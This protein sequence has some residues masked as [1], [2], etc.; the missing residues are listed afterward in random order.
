V[1]N[2][3]SSYHA[4]LGRPALAKFMAVSHYVYVLLKMPGKIGVLTFPG[5]LK[6]SYDCD[7]EAIEYA[8][9]TLMAEPS[10]KVFVAT[11]Q[12]S[13]SEMV[14]LTKKS[15]QSTVKLNTNDIGM[16]FIQL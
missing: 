14:I 10:A 9:T 3:E 5:N 15:S 2:F 11:Q 6:K 12:L 16:K 7:Q 4:I 1:A 8:S 13:Q